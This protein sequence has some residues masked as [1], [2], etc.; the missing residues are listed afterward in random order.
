VIGHTGGHH[1]MTIVPP[2]SH[3]KQERSMDAQRFDAIIRLL[4]ERPSRRDVLRRLSGSGLIAIAG[5]RLAA[6]DIAARGKHGKKRKKRKQ[7]QQ[8]ASAGAAPLPPPVL[9]AF[10]CVDVSQPCRGD[11]SLCCS[12]ICGGPAPRP[13]ESDQSR[14]LAH[15]TSTCQSGQRDAYCADGAA[16]VL[17]T[18][19]AGNQNG[20]CNTTTGNGA[21][22]MRA[23]YC[24]ACTRDA[25]CQ[26]FCGSSAACVLC[27]L[28]AAEGGTMCASPSLGSC[29]FPPP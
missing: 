29:Q 23:G 14:C 6:P 20:S 22:C 18:T 8:P 21:Y 24:R 3:R 10:G 4:T 27:S 5:E 2:P 9:N 17:C 15:D 1:L 12:G 13:G 16:E 28:C 7:R 26:V 25:D 19:S 11:S